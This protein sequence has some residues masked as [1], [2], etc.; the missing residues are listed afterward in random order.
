MQDETEQDALWIAAGELQYNIHID[1]L[2]EAVSQLEQYNISEA[3]NK[4]KGNR[5]KAAEELGIG[6]TNLIAKIK[7]YKMKF[8]EYT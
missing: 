6:R 1:K 7:K 8:N 4:H 2:P 5:T 3:I